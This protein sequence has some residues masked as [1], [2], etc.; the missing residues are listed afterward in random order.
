[1]KPRNP[2]AD[3]ALACM[4]VVSL[5][6]TYEAKMESLPCPF[7]F[8]LLLDR[9]AQCQSVELRW[10]RNIVVPNEHEATVV[11]RPWIPWTPNEQIEWYCA[12]GRG[13]YRRSIC[14]MPWYHPNHSKAPCRSHAVILLHHAF[15][16]NLT[17]PS[18]SF[19]STSSPS[20]FPLR[21]ISR[22]PNSLSSQ[23]NS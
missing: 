11:K 4:C 1:M 17:G 3:Q 10:W 14:S 9:S 18:R 16:R 20:T 2:S 13:K 12:S 15:L 7:G 23:A 22:S 8:L 6:Q 21:S 19:I 5:Q